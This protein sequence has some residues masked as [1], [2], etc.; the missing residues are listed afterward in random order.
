MSSKRNII[1]GVIAVIVVGFIVLQ[2]IP[3]FAPTN[4]AVQYK[5]TWS[6]AET[7]SMMRR[8]CYDCH[9]NETIWP[10]YAQFAPISWLVVHDV[11][12]GRQKLNFSE[13]TG[14]MEAR[15]LIRQIESDKMPP[16]IYLTMHPD[17]NLTA[18]EKAA[19][20]A[21]IQATSFTGAG[22]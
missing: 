19:L 11:N 2:V 13:G 20:I 9:S 6:S 7:A 21:G 10:W 5:V 12:E 3:G 1:L 15:E 4:P 8:A 17:A 16:K 22:G 14:E 18:D